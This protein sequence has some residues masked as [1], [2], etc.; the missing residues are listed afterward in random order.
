MCGFIAQLA[1]HRTGIAE[2]T[3][4]NPVEALIFFRLLHSNCL[5]WKFTAKITYHLH[6]YPQF[7][8]E[9]FHI[10]HVI[11]LLS[12]EN[13]N[14]QLTSLPMCG[15]IAQ[16]V[17]HRTGIAEVT[18]SNPVEALIFFRLLHS[19]CLNWKF[20]AKITYHLHIY[21]QFIY[22]SFHI[23]HV[24]SL[25]SRENKN[26]QLTSLPMCGFIA[27]LVE[28]RT[29]IAEVTGSNPVEALIFFRLLH[30]NCLNWKF[31]A[32][33]TYHLHIYPQ[34]IYESFHILHVISLLSRENKNSQLTSLPMCG[35]IAQLVEHRTGIAEVTGSN[36][37]E[38]LIFFRLLHSNCLNWKFTAKITYHLHIYPQFIYE[39]FHILHV[40]SLLSRE[41]KNSQLT[42]LPMCGFIAQLV[43]HRTGIAEVTG[44]NPVEALIFFR[45]LHSN[46]LNW[47]FTAKITYH[48]HIYPQFIYESFHIL[49]VISLLSREN[50][51]SQLTS[52]PMCGF[53]AQLVEHRTGIAEVTGSNPVEAL[54]FFRLLHSNCL[55]WKFTAK[56]TYH[57]HI[58]PQFIYESFHILHVISLL[59]RENKNSQ[60]TSLPMCG[61]IAQ[62]VEH[63]TGIAEVTG[64]N[65]VEALIFF[66]LLHSNCLNWKF[67]AKITYHLHIYPQFIYESFHILHVILITAALSGTI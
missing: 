46:C 23:L 49:H 20:T 8:Y 9:S 34:F 36:P 42:S 18:G 54:I 10:L 41:N 16:L 3:G 66:R 27:Q 26:S 29:G 45:L 58:Y 4:S 5:N 65:P 19:N 57:L 39:S 40:I 12:R 38:A 24:I 14:S 48:L 6:I 62:L 21:P 25:L 56:I 44:S 15:F 53:I 7:I 55:N 64:S 30:S 47:K 50:K 52:L 22:E 31:T 63:R 61:F 11:S 51:N 60:L 2:V 35:F 43:E 32:K 13:K 67:T 37:V 17:E 1:E 59:S 33:I 28:H